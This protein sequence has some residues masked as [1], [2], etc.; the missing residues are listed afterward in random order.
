MLDVIPDGL[1]A[2]LGAPVSLC[3][4]NEP[5][6]VAHAFNNCCRFDSAASLFID[7]CAPW[8]NAWI[9]SSSDLLGGRA[10]QRVAL[11]LLSTTRRSVVAQSNN[12]RRS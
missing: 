1:A 9:E 11:D 4:D 12:A 5:E 7:H 10:A 8:Q 2:R 3:F 6:F